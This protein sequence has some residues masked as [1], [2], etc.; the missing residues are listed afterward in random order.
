MARNPLVERYYNRVKDKFPQLNESEFHDAINSTFR[1]FKK[2]MGSEDLP[3]VRLKGFGSFQIFAKPVL[4]GIRRLEEKV[5]TYRHFNH[6]V[7]NYECYQQLQNLKKYVKEN[8][9]LFNEAIKRR[10]KMD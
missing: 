6:P 7:E 1:Y 2:R 10:A 8:P 9:L 3:D 5:S 4:S